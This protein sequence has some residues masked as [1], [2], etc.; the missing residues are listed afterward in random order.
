MSEIK[1]ASEEQLSLE[2]AFH[3]VEESIRKL[4]AEDI[5]LDASFLAYREGIELLKLCSDKI[6]RVEKQIVMM[7]EKGEENEF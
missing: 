6:D 3:R 2:E 7:N 5:S 4:E 1:E